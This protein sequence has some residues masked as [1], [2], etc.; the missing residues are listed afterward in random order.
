MLIDHNAI[1]AHVV[2]RGGHTA[3]PAL[4]DELRAALRAR[5]APYK[6]PRALHFTAALPHSVQGKVLRRALQP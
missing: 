5:I 3:A 4:A 1:E 6:V 2:L